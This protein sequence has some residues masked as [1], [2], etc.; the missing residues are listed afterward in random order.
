MLTLTVGLRMVMT[1]C[2]IELIGALPEDHTSIGSA[3]NDTAQ[4]LG[5]AVG[6]A[7]VGTVTAA[8]VGTVLPTGAWSA[9][10]V[11]DFFHAVQLSFGILAVVATV[12]SIMGVRRLSNATTLEE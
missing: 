1:T 6:V 8:V 11:H 7:I 3:M 5:N 4:E 9:H 12:V 10:L 2:A